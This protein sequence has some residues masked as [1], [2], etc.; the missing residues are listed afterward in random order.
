M[1][2]TKTADRSA[3]TTSKSTAKKATDQQK[4]AA[5]DQV[6]QILQVDAESRIKKAEQFQLL[7]TKYKT[8][9][10]KKDELESFMISSDGT[11]ER[12][13]LENAKGMK[14]IVSN[15]QVIEKVIQMI[16]DQ[17]DIYIDKTEQ[18]VKAFTI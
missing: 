1:S 9:K 16:T 3:R 12:I 11:N 4:K 2:N 14:F 7:A 15:S 5:K 8:L 18:E 6:K 10:A 13:Y 17:L